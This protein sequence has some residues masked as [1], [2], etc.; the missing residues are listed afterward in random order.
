MN[1]LEA[2][3]KL[4]GI[5]EAGEA[6]GL[7]SQLKAHLG[8]CELCQHRHSDLQLK[9]TL[10]QIAVPEPSA[11]FVEQS[12]KHAISEHDGGTKKYRAL[13]GSAAAMLFFAMTFSFVFKQD[14]GLLNGEAEG[15]YEMQMAINQTKNINVVLQSDSYRANATIRVLV[16]ENLQL[17]GYDNNRELSWQTELVE[18][19]NVITLPLILQ[20]AAGGYVDITYRSGADTGTLRVSVSET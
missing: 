14:A 17:Q 8:S 20:S 13:A 10:H 11:K 7:D 19:K 18:G 12:I 9:H 16:A 15:L 5:I 4:G 2:Q 6:I 1:C 3:Q